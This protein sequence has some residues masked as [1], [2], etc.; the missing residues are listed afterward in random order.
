MLSI[1]AREADIIG[2]QTVSTANGVVSNDPSVRLAPAV[3][4]KVDQVRQMAGD[5]FGE[6]ELSMV[7]TVVV[8]GERRPAA[9]QFARERGWAGVS[10]DQVLEM[11]S[12]FIGSEDQVVED[13]RARRERYGF[14]YYVVL[15]HA[16]ERV[17]PVVARLAGR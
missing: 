2:F 4:K 12:I 3:A 15:D 17:A 11:P 13:M 9:E 5:R 7:A 6:I 1:A 16:M 10:A 14:S 8:A